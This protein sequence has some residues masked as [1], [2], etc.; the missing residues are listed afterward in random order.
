VVEAVVIDLVAVVG[1]T[2]AGKTSLGVSLAERVGGEVVSADAFAV[3]RGMDI[4]TA[5]PT[6]AERLRVPHRIIDIADPRERYS[7]GSFVRD[8][9]AAIAAIRGRGRLPVVVGGTLFYVRA[10]LR[11]RPAGQ[12]LRGAAGIDGDPA[13]AR[14]WPRADRVVLPDR[15][16]RPAADPALEVAEPS[17]GR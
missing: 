17:A 15:A 9:D 5:K 11:G 1:P 10:L 4:G 16:G 2:A 6:P 7:A 13:V 14:D 8:A 3:Y 12:R